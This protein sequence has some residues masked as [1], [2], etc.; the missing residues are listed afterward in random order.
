MIKMEELLKGAKLE[1][2]SPEIQANLKVLLERLNA[3]RAAYGKPMFVT[4]GLRTMA[5]HKRIYA[6]K[7]IT[8]EKKIPMKSKHLSGEAG[9]IGD[10]KREL[11]AW[12]KANE[13]K[14]AEIGLWM[15]DFS[16]TPTWVHF[17]VVPPKSG[18]RFFMP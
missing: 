1:D 4:S 14:L 9:D 15:E 3:V 13:A 12:C 2:Q 11:Q 8:D 5:D 10:A 17:Q 7:G 16:A 18:K 6:A